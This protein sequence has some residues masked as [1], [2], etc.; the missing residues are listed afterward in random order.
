MTKAINKQ[1][2][3][4]KPQVKTPMLGV[5]TIIIGVLSSLIGVPGT[6]NK[7]FVLKLI[8][9]L[10]FSGIYIYLLAYYSK[11]EVNLSKVNC[12]LKESIELYEEICIN[13]ISNANGT[14]SK[15]NTIVHKSTQADVIDLNIWNFDDACKAVCMQI[16]KMLQKATSQKGF[17]V[18]YVKLDESCK[19]AEFVILNAFANKTGSRPDIYNQRRPIVDTNSYHDIEL[20]REGK[21]DIEAVSDKAEVSKI[22][23]DGKGK[24]KDKYEQYIGIPVLCDDTKMIGL[25]QI[26][27]VDGS[28]LGNDKKELEEFAGKYLIPF[29]NLLL[30]FHKVEKVLRFKSVKHDSNKVERK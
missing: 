8:L 10:V 30:L 21:S 28:T 13:I 14:A 9:L 1:K 15:L 5:L 26:I 29:T 7:W 20:F 19:E 25:L 27:C 2:F 18:N 6:E 16:Y 24:D 12:V 23:R 4:N 11:E 3:I 22:F 17:L